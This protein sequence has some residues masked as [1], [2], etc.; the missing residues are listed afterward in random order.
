M[1][2]ACIGNTFRSS[3]MTCINGRENIHVNCQE[4]LVKNKKCYSST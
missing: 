2:A 1:T 3:L 4:I